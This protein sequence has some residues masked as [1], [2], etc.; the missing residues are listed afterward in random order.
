MRLL[1][2]TGP[3]VI[4]R[5]LVVAALF[6]A[7]GC[8]TK[9]GAKY[10]D[11]SSFCNGRASAEC[12]SEVLLACVIP[13]ATTCIAKRQQLCMSAAPAGTN[14]NPSAAESCIAQVSAAY[15]DA[16]ITL[17]ESNAI[18]SACLP[19]FDG[20]GGPS[21]SCQIDSN[22][23]RSA[24]LRC[25]VSAASGGGV[26]LV[27]LAVQGGGSCAAANAR[28]VTG[29]HCGPTAHCDIDAAVGEACSGPNPCGADLMCSS[30]GTCVAKS[31]DGSAC[32][33]GDECVHGICNK[34]MTS[35]TGL[36]VSQVNIASNEPFCVDSR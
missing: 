25:V 11:L 34:S 24:G 4:G 28:C 19:V 20:P 7:V 2:L 6:L 9:N 29:F 16:R 13:S 26:C 1:M 21:A 27:P 23:M 33:S 35:A 3:S 31:A 30:G 36:C 22:C 5:P 10:P 12:N 32:A 15:A 14:Y 17:D 18:D 8:S